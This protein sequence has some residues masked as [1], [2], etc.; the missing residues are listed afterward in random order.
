MRELLSFGFVGFIGTVITIGGA[1]LL[2][3]WLG[4]SPL[5]SV[6]IPTAVSTLSSYLLNR[7]WTFRGSDSDGSGREVALFFGLNAVGAAIQV[8]CT[9]FTYYTLGLHSGFAYNLALL[10]GLGLA[11]A[12][13]Y[14]SYKKWIFTPHPV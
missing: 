6:V 11:S 13:R 5:T 14:W 3:H 12:F 10:A 8:L 2:R 4:G 7:Y 1:N 9:G